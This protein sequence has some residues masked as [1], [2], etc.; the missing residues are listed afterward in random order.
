MISAHIDAAAAPAEWADAESH[1][2]T[3]AVCRTWQATAE[4]VNRALR[5]R[6]VEAVPDLA[7]AV[8]ARS[9]PTWR[10]WGSWV[11]WA[12]GA[13]ATI[14]LVLATSGFLA[15]RGAATVHDARHIGSFGSAIAIGL[16]YVAIRPERAF[17]LLP[18][19]VA[20]SVTMSVSAVIDVTHGR[21]TGFAEAHHALEVSGLLLVWVLAGRPLP[22]RRGPLVRRRGLKPFST[23]G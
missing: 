14:E 13:V 2:A 9:H 10:G 7:S 16:L 19:V 17:G 11:R 21:T 4:A 5:V 23:F 18:I 20:L 3:C 6:P 1:L 12:L 8:L 15:G 22:R